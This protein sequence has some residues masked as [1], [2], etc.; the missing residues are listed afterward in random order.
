VWVKNWLRA[1]STAWELETPAYNVYFW[2]KGLA[3]A[4]IPADRVA[5]SSA[6]FEIRGAAD[7][8]R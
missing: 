3:P 2:E 5:P 7:G 6:E 8:A 4:G 1:S